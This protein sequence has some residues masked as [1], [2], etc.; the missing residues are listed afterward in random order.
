M[1]DFFSK[2]LVTVVLV[3]LGLIAWVIT[4]AARIESKRSGH[5]VSGIPAVGGILIAAG[6]LLS[7]IKC[8]A[9]IG[10]LDFDLWYL[11]VV[12]IPGMLKAERQIKN[13]TPP[14]VFDGKKVIEFTKYNKCYE[15]IRFPAEYPNATEIHTIH[16]YIIVESG[17]KFEL[18]K[19]ENAEKII[20]I[21]V[22]N[23]VK[24]CHIHASDKAKW[25][26]K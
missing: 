21:E 15:E 6:F 5:F 24:D 9:L 23:S 4:I 25:L 7:P 14:D 2:N 1:I 18:Y 3:A 8:L 26:V 13:Y 20:A 22:Y 16:H 11:L 12:V 17:D 19:I 10:L